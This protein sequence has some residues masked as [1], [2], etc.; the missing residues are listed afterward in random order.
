MLGGESE[1]TGYLYRS[2]FVTSQNEIVAALESLGR[3]KW[4]VIRG[5]VEE[6]VRERK[7]RMEKGFFDGAMMLLERNVLFGE[8]GNINAWSEDEAQ[9]ERNCRLFRVA[10]VMIGRLDNEGKPDC[11]CG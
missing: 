8:V 5:D 9:A 2:E 7:T 3:K 11:G 6:C 1:K 4:D 10:K